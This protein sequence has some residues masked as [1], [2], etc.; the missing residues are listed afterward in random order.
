[1]TFIRFDRTDLKVDDLLLGD[2]A[3]AS[4]PE[5]YARLCHLLEHSEAMLS[6][7]AEVIEHDPSLTAR[8]LRIA[9]SPFFGLSH[10]IH[11]IGEAVSVVGVRELKQLVLA[12][13]VIRHFEGIPPG[14]IDI[15]LFWRQSVRCAV[16]ARLLAARRS[17]GDPEHLFIAAL[18]HGIGHL[19]IYMRLP[20]LGRKTLLE[21]RYRGQ[22]LYEAQREVIGFDYA[23][24]GAALARHWKLPEL[25]CAV[26]AHHIHPQQAASYQAEVALV[27]LALAASRA[28]SFRPEEVRDYLPREPNTWAQAGLT[29]DTLEAVLPEADA[30]FSAALSLIR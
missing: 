17:M 13:E 27:H 21:H 1:M 9:N 14:L 23:E 4:P 30:A 29:P 2:I 10:P 6:A 25:L 8:L 16:I 19:V 24:V 26:L 18:L 22:P 12:T 5:I 7:V 20:E 28:P 11:S 15:Y 3:L